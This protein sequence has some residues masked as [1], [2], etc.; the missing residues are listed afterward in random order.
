MD[1]VHNRR[2]SELSDL[3][4]GV[5]LATSQ[6]DST[7]TVVLA[8]IS[9][10]LVIDPAWS[11]AELDD[12]SAQ[13]Q[14]R[15]LTVVS[16]IA[17]HAHFDHLLWHPDFGPA[18]RYASRA[19]IT[20]AQ[21]RR[22]ELLREWETSLAPADGAHTTT[23]LA[24]LRSV[25]AQLTA[26]PHAPANPDSV[27]LPRGATP[28]GF[29]P[30]LIV[31]NAHIAG[32]IAVWLPEQ[33]ILIAGDMLSDIEPPLPDLEVEATARRINRAPFHPGAATPGTPLEGI[34]ERARQDYLAGLDA[35]E[36]YAREARLV[37]PGHGT[38]GS[39]ALARLERDRAALTAS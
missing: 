14:E 1:G 22:E 12:L 28:Q 6:H 21:A 3:A 29:A 17:T 16:G 35:L 32:H 24:P 15:G 19:T 27:W 13:L 5:L 8:S 11:P 2:M 37:I 30:E 34:P 26:P 39:D 18:P 7:N 23:R 36:P 4:P 10:A 20:L 33:R 31:H 38:V 9:Q 25:F